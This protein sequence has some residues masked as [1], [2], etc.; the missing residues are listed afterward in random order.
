MANSVNTRT[1]VR[2][3]VMLKRK[4]IVKWFDMLKG[5]AYFVIRMSRSPPA[6]SHT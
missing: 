1:T 3:E 2:K 5:V 6:L 4:K